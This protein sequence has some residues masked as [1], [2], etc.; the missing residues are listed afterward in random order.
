M[1]SKMM[2]QKMFMKWL[3]DFKHREF[4]KDKSNEFAF[5]EVYKAIYEQAAQDVKEELE[6][7][8]YVELE[9]EYERGYEEGYRIGYEEA[10]M[11]D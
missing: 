3:M 5:Y 2:N 11:R 8:H 6:N 7:I 9:S 10:E 4:V 1:Y